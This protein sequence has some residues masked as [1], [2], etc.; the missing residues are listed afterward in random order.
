MALTECRDCGEEVSTRADACPNCGCPVSVREASSNA[1]NSQNGSGVDVD[2]SDSWEDPSKHDPLGVESASSAKA[3]NRRVWYWLIGIPA[4]GF[5]CLIALAAVVSVCNQPSSSSNTTAASDMNREPERPDAV[6]SEEEEDEEY[7]KKIEAIT[8][9]KRFVK[10]RLKAPATAEFPWSMS[11]TDAVHRTDKGVY[12]VISHVDSENLMGAKV[13]ADFN[14]RMRLDD[15]NW[16]L[17]DLKMSQ[18]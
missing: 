12:E 14:C 10:S 15:G 8:A 3:E 13:R 1:S 5:A 4:G 18:R 9:C 17:V 16:K 2:F 7:G 6:E 11:E